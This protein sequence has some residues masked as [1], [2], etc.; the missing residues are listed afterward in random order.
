MT[1]RM[2]KRAIFILYILALTGILFFG[3]T[4]AIPFLFAGHPGCHTDADSADV[5]S[6]V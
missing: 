1:K 3:E 4:E 5:I 2:V 6:V